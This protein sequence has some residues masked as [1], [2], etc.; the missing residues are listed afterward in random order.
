MAEEEKRRP[1]R[2]RPEATEKGPALIYANFVQVNHT[3]WDFTLHFGNFFLPPEA[4]Q[5]KESQEAAE[6]ELEVKSVARISV[7][8]R[9]IRGIVRALETNIKRYEDSY[10]VLP[11][12]RPEE[13]EG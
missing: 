3:P 8:T 7:P 2:L 1:V 9:L 13:E 4:P 10:G 6:F 11:D 5:A 12:S